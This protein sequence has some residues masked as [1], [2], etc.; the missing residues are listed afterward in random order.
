MRGAMYTPVGN[1]CQPAAHL[2][3][4]LRE[5]VRLA[6][7]QSAEEVAPHILYARFNLALGLRTIESYAE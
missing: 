3:V 7:Q 2:A 5:V 1:L 4:E 6:S